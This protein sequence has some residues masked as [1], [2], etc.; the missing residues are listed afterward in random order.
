MM[1]VSP[2]RLPFCNCCALTRLCFSE[3]V[4]YFP[5]TSVS[6]IVARQMAGYVSYLVESIEV[7]SVIEELVQGD[8]LLKV[9]CVIHGERLRHFHQALLVVVYK[10]LDY[11]RVL[12]QRLR[13]QVLVHSFILQE[14]QY[15]IL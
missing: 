15:F 4:R 5:Q 14:Y 2:P 13:F 9:I 12:K 11:F 10:L 1:S 8:G 6:R 7:V 3:F